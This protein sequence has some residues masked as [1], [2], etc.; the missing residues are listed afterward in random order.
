[1]PR[2]QSKGSEGLKSVLQKALELEWGSQGLF[3]GPGYS[4]RPRALPGKGLAENC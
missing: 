1:M 3:P 4:L 2:D